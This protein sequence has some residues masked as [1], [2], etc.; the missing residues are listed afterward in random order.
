MFFQPPTTS[1]P[2]HRSPP[3]LNACVALSAGL[4]PMLAAPMQGRTDAMLSQAVAVAVQRG[5]VE[6]HQHVVCVESVKEVLTLKVVAVDALGQGMRRSSEGSQ[7]AGAH[8]RLGLVCWEHCSPRQ[9]AGLHA[10]HASTCAEMRAGCSTRF[11]AGHQRYHALSVRMHQRHHQCLSAERGLVHVQATYP[12]SIRR[13]RTGC[14]P[15]SA[16]NC[17]PTS[18]VIQKVSASQAHSTNWLRSFQNPRSSRD[19]AIRNARPLS[20]AVHAAAAMDHATY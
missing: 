19:A 5:L 11:N 6:P 9:Y 17:R 1:M 3:E 10:C 12:R 4:S 20:S 7:H 16:E 15:R 14:C 8:S 18:M 2:A 13:K